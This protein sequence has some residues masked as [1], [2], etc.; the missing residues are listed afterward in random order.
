[1]NV[2]IAL[3]G[4]IFLFLLVEN[5]HLYQV[6]VSLKINQIKV[7]ARNKSGEGFF[8]DGI[9]LPHPPKTNINV[10]NVIKYQVSES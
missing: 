1:M 6:I 9:V 2:F 10:K 8:S 4:T 7:D 3:K 5:L